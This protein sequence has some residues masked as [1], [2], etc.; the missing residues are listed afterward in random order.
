M[1]LKEYYSEFAS[2][3]KKINGS[4]KKLTLSYVSIFLAIVIL[5]TATYSWFV[6][7]DTANI[8]S[9]S[10][11]LEAVSGLRVNEGEDLK[12][13]ITLENFR[14]E[15]ASS[16]DGRNFFFPTTG[17]FSSNTGNMKFREGNV[18]DKNIKYAY[19]DFVLKG[20]TKGTY[21]YVKG[22]TIKVGDEVF[23]GSTKIRYQD[24]KPVEQLKHEKCPI[25][26]A[27]IT[28]SE[29]NP[30]VFDPTALIDDYVNHYNAVNYTDETGMPITVDASAKSFSDYYYVTGSSLFTLDSTPLNVTMVVWL[31][32]TGENWEAYA[33]KDI[34]VDI[35]LESN[36]AD[37][38]NVT[39]VDNTLGDNGVQTHWVS[40]K[41]DGV[42]CILIMTYTDTRSTAENKVKSVVMKKQKNPTTG[43]NEW[44]APLPNYVSTDIA[45][46]RYDP[47]TEI[48]Y[49]AWYTKKGVMDEVNSEIKT[50]EGWIPTYGDLQEDRLNENGKCELQYTAVRGNKYNKTNNEAERLSPCLGYW[51][52]V[53]VGGGEG[54]GGGGGAVSGDEI[55]IKANLNIDQSFTDIINALNSGGKVY[56]QFT[57]D[58]EVEC[59]TVEVQGGARCVWGEFK[60][61]AGTSFD[62]VIIKD[63]AGNTVDTLSFNRQISVQSGWE[64][65]FNVDTSTGELR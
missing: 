19:K 43:L 61:I 20:D 7:R 18:G 54:G 49:N 46:Y 42:E 30:T 34:S 64:Y 10:F 63:S 38:E 29:K 48:I 13:H 25:R 31:E 50:T 27:L 55:T 40:D 59:P 51:G 58:R 22:Y 44:T 39:F 1:I 37:M 4:R 56:L 53:T 12:N 8:D 21:V 16:V 11:K 52:N 5:V 17:T 32:G 41:V 33:D 47:K 35:E 3:F 24:G 23:D 45:F 65:N 15:E 60:V 28:D 62:H 57:D 6:I 2:A 14:L 9:D 36:W 26:V